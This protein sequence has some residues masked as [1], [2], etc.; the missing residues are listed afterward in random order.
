VTV[1]VLTE[2][3]EA[4][5]DAHGL[6]TAAAAVIPRVEDRTPL[7]EL[8]SELRTLERQAAE[9]RARCLDAEERH[10][11]SVRDEL[12]ARMN[13]TRERSSDLA[14]AWFKAGTGPLAAW[15]FLAM[16]EAAELA[17]WKAVSVLATKAGE[18][19]LSELAAWALPLQ[20]RHLEAALAA[21]VRLAGLA[22]PLGPR[23]GGD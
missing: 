3:Q 13:A 10:A 2:L 14:N 4:L 15:R 8:V 7:G 9:V 17:A 6:A 20:E 1:S 18:A 19:R 11:D 12:L 16:G 21:T 5:A 22:D 23:W